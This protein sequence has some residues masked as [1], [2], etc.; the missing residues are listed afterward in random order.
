MAGRRRSLRCWPT[1][2]TCASDRW[3]APPPPPG[4][5]GAPFL[6]FFDI[7]CVE[8]ILLRGCSHMSHAVVSCHGD[9]LPS[10][11]VACIPHR[12]QRAAPLRTLCARQARCRLAQSLLWE[13]LSAAL[14]GHNFDILLPRLGTGSGM[15]IW[16]RIWR[17]R[18]AP[19]SRWRR[20]WTPA[21]RCPPIWPTM[22]PTRCACRNVDISERQEY[23]RFLL[24]YG[25]THSTSAVLSAYKADNDANELGMSEGGRRTYPMWGDSPTRA[26][27]M[28]A[29]AFKNRQRN[30]RARFHPNGTQSG[31]RPIPHVYRL[32]CDQSRPIKNAPAS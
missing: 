12:H 16:R 6:P 15:Q 26:M 29:S 13:P 2:R 17:M 10:N 32:S 30:F 1:G 19:R 8:H 3:T 31:F 21:R 27:C 14:P 9:C 20:Q 11:P 18:S 25:C 7:H 23:I 28:Q 24:S 5:P 22:T 4:Q